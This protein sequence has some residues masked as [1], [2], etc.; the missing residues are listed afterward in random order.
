MELSQLQYFYE[1]A[2]TE[3][4]AKTAERH[5]VPTSSVSGSVRRL[6]KELGCQLFDRSSNRL[7]LN[8]NGRRLFRAL[9]VAFDAVGDAIKDLTSASQDDREIKMLV[10][11]MRGKITDC[12][13][14]HNRIRPHINFR[15]NFDKA[16]QDFEQYDI[17]IDEKTDAYPTHERMELCHMRLQLTTS[18]ESPLCSRKLTMK[19]LASQPFISLGQSSNMH[20]ILV[21]ACKRA[22]FSP[23]I[24]IFSNDM[25]YYE[26]LVESGIGI[27]IERNNP[28]S[29]RWRNIAYLEVADF[30]E[31]STVYAYFKRETAYGNVE[32]FLQFLQSKD[33]L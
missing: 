21:D 26:K 23:N 22:G 28:S 15:I 19:Q 29:L 27:G 25:K 16:E 31:E 2:K 30:Q 7:M 14:E 4:F 11:A 6:E 13:I 32:Q 17:I 1:S 10:R 8:Q 20:K 5:L 9:Q 24:A 18:R 33:F 3:N 12:V